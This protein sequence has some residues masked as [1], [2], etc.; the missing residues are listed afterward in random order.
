MFGRDL[1]ETLANVAR[2]SKKDAQTFR[3]WNRKAEEIT[4]KIFLP[5]RFSDPLPQA[6][7]EALLSQSDIG[8]DFLAVTRR[9][10]FDVV[11][12]LFENEHVQLL[13]LFKMSLFGT[14]LVDT[15]S[16]T[17]PMG[18]VIRAFDLQSGYQLCKGGSGNLARG[19][20][21]DLHRRGR[22]LRAAGR[23]RQDRD[24]RRQGDRHRAEGRPHRARQAVR[25]LDA[26][27]CIRPSRTTSAARS[28]RRRS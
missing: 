17:S 1:E 2:F 3:D 8:R 6:E 25:R 24:R 20:V 15:M 13:F 11:K 22:A 21:R 14:W 16:K 18:S 4:A 28:C 10:P 7:R 12:E 5:E 19:A 9:Q 27:T 26:R 23:A